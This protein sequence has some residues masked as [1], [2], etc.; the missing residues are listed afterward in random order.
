MILWPGHCSTHNNIRKEDILKLK[1]KHP[2]AE[3]LVHPECR[4][5]VID[6]ADHTFSTNGMINYIKK[7]NKKKFIIGTEKDICYRFKC[8]NSEKEF[9]PIPSA[10]CKN[11]KKITAEK[12]LES[13]KALKPEIDLSN[14]ILKE[15]KEP[16]QKMMDIGRGD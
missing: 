2:A 4:L 3:V 15:A 12:I 6:I 11:M 8:E 16:L 10:I 7:S 1:S 5:D 13:L 9:Y 14:E